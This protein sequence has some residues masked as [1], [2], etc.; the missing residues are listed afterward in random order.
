LE[1][2]HVVVDKVVGKGG[3]NAARTVALDNLKPL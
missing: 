2:N 3:M 1:E